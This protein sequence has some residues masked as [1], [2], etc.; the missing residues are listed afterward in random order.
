MAQRFSKPFYNSKQWQQVRD[1]VLRRDRYL[2]TRCGDP[3][4]EVHHIERLTPENVGDPS[5]SLNSDNLISLCR[6]CHFREHEIERLPSKDEAG[7][8][9]MFDANGYLI[10]VWGIPPIE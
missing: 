7:S 6:D 9:L 3:A 10:P 4:E 2:C 1:Y 8:G 5:V